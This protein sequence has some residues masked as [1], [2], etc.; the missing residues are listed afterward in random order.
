MGRRFCIC[1][2]TIF[3]VIESA[4]LKPI[5]NISVPARLGKG[6]GAKEIGHNIVRER[7]KFGRVSDQVG[8]F[9]TRTPKI[10]AQ[11]SSRTKQDLGTNLQALYRSSAV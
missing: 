7:P 10:R 3:S 11:S 5:S 4:A 8:H 9:F 2:E 6:Q 1:R